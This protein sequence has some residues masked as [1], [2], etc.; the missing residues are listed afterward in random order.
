MEFLAGLSAALSARVGGATPG[1]VALLNERRGTQRSGFM[2]AAGIVV[3]SA[4]GL[5]DGALRAVLPG[6]GS[7][8]A[9]PAGRDASTNVAVFRLLDAGAQQPTPWPEAAEPTVGMLALLLGA[10]GAGGPAVRLGLVNALGGAWTSMA[11]G[12]IDRLIRLD[13]KLL[14]AEEGGPVL[15]A[16]GGLIGMSTLGPRR[17]ALVIP[18]STIVRVVEAILS[19]GQ[20]T[21]GWLGVSLHPVAVPQALHAGVD[22]GLMI[23]ALAAGGPAEQA[24]LLPGD[25]ILGLDGEAAGAPRAIAAALAAQPVGRSVTLRLLRG[26]VLQPVDAVIGERPSC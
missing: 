25:I 19:K 21:P 18:A 4:Q 15:D 1:L 13:A 7:V 6:G 24:G 11:G 10:D 5:P 26:G 2:W 3:T 9:V 8:D 20:V 23:M 17:R 14:P 16:A 22:E 12:R